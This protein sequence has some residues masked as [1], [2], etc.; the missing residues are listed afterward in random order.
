MGLFDRVAA[1]F[2]DHRDPRL[3]EHSVATLVAQRI[4]ALALGYEDLNDHDQLRHDPVLGLLGDKTGATR[5]DCA[6]LAGKSTLD[7]L[8]HAPQGG[9]P[10]RY[11]RISHDPQAMQALL[12]ELFIESRTGPLPARLILDI[13][14]IDDETHGGQEGHFFHGY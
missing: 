1:C 13:D 9:E 12:T 14:C 4:V 3:T 8:E 2:T 7:R 6:A 10:G 5:K 11:H